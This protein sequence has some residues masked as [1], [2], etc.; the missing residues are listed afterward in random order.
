MTYKSFVF[1]LVATVATVNLFVFSLAGLSLLKS[2]KQHKQEVVTQTQNLATTLEL[3]VRGIVAKIDL[4]LLDVVDE[5]EHRLRNGKT[6]D[7]ASHLDVHRQ[8]VPELYSLRIV[9]RNGTVTYG[10]RLGAGNTFSI[11]DR[12]YFIKLRDDAGAGLVIS[13]P[14]LGVISKSWLL[15][16]A[17]RINNPDGS[18]AGLAQ[19]TIEIDKLAQIFS[20][21]DLGKQGVVTLRDAALNVVARWPEMQDGISTINSSKVSSELQRLVA[22][23]NTS[24]TYVTKG[25]IDTVER[26]FSYQRLS[27]YPLLVNV[28][29]S[30]N[31]YISKW[32]TDAAPIAL[33][34]L[35]FISGSLFSSRQIFLKWS[36]E[37][38]AEEE[39]RQANML[40]ETRVV[41]RTEELSKTN[42][43]L[44]VEL[45]E[46]K[47]AE[48]ARNKAHT[49]VE[50]LLSSL[51][52]G[53]IVYEG[54]SGDCV[55]ANK[56]AAHIIGATLEQVH[57]QN[58]R[59]LS[60]WK[61][62]GF[63]EAAG[64]VLL[65][66][67]TRDLEG[68]GISS[69]GKPICVQALFSRFDEGPVRH[70]LVILIDLSEKK[71]LE[72]E[73]RLM[74]LQMFH[75]QKL[76]SLGV[77]AG[78][79]A[80]DFNN[81]LSAILGNLEL[82]L[83]RL[84]PDSP[85]RENL[86]QGKKAANR[87]ADLAQQML[88]YSGKGHFAVESLNINMVVEEMTELLT[89]SISKKTRMDFNFGPD[90]PHIDAD[91]TQI[92][93]VILNLVINASEA[94]LNESGSISLTT[95]V[96]ECD[97]TYFTNAWIVDQLTEG[98]YVFVEV[99]DT[100]CGIGSDVLPKI[101]DPFFST[102]F[103]GRGLGMA[104]V[105]G[106]VR[107][108]KG[109]IHVFSE[110]DKGTRIKVLFPVSTKP[111]QTLKANDETPRRQQGHGTVLLV[112]D[113]EAILLMGRELLKELGYE[114]LTASDGRQGVDVFRK[115]RAEI[116]CVILDL[117]MPDMDGRETFNVIR[118]MDPDMPI[119][120][121]SGYSQQEVSKELSEY[122]QT[123]F[124][125]KPYD[126]RTMQEAL[127]GLMTGT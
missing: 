67:T 44:V 125:Q 31:D 81:I 26:T 40:L 119:L 117:T 61:E 14:V 69:F 9:D 111:V 64:S 89:I 41:Q 79:I 60:S 30:S 57:A 1:R 6:L 122:R 107:G 24:G 112:D 73:K 56:A 66:G 85:V 88:A 59:S 22:K 21:I 51:P 50:T 108:H 102:K 114:V 98:L 84:D 18:F 83:M 36:S 34:V 77:L 32:Q 29:R 115:K 97:E 70:L 54:E 28:G 94:L 13:K 38:A 7:L 92:R 118:L 23:G 35:L 5:A 96:I 95:G 123:L 68:I 100:G 75:V 20:S 52:T 8:R 124:I 113:E 74:E 82:A 101:F 25:S 16:F 104:T 109:A 110:P 116:A 48:A 53:I 91:A 49:F 12:E 90:L 126:V 19:A 46:R 10:N 78:G 2:L 80:H 43:Q 76:E 105:M 86:E 33:L 47:R 42:Q 71:T 106:I 62:T 103:A 45:G 99:T 55:L 127:S 87:A 39:L 72:D 15:G 27:G 65:D 37:K 58:F 11:A 17:R 3:S 120:M 121:C 93:Q 4:I 63:A